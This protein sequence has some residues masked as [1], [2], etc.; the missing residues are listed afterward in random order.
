MTFANLSAF[1]LFSLL[2]IILL[3]YFLKGKRQDKVI[4]STILWKNV[5]TD[6]LSFNPRWRLKPELLLFFHL[7]IA[8]LL[9]TA[10]MQ[11]YTRYSTE[12]L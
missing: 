7:L 11:P 6:S 8:A 10:L 12:I 2:G 9:V 1:V 4:S 3:I 5:S